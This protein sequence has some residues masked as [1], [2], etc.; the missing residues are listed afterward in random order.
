MYCYLQ[1]RPECR[2]PFPS[3]LKLHVQCKLCCAVYMEF[4]V[5]CTWSFVQCVVFNCSVITTK[6]LW[7]TYQKGKRC[8]IAKYTNAASSHTELVIIIFQI[9]LPTLKVIILFAKNNFD[10]KVARFHI[11]TIYHFKRKANAR[12]KIVRVCES[13]STHVLINLQMQIAHSS[14]SSRWR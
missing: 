11:K 1:R 12:L 9:N 14:S 7:S 10:T 5:H 2:S 6:P 4:C 3:I 13:V 8:V